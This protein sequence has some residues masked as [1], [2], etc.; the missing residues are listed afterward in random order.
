MKILLDENLP[1]RLR[2]LLIGH[3]V[4][5]VAFMK[6]NGVENGELLTLA[7]ADGF[8][9]VITKDT[10]MPYEQNTQTLPCSIV[11]L[12]AP[13]NELDDI[14]PLI[15]ALLICLQALPPRSFARVK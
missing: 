8:E 1:H 11:V 4:F 6:W 10:G 13:T 15:P 2:P 14:R 3:D 9:A 7:A 12:E 5:T